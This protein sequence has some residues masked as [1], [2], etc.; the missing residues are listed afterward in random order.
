MKWVMVFMAVGVVCLAAGVS[1]EQY[2]QLRVYPESGAEWGVLR[3]L[4]LDVAASGP[5]WMEIISSPEEYAQLSAE[6]LRIEVLQEDLERFYAERLGAKAGMGGYMTLAEVNA[7]LDTLVMNFPDLVSAKVQIGTTHEGRPIWAVKI[8]DNPNVDEDEPELLFTAA[9]HAREVIT[10][11]TVFNIMEYLAGYYNYMPEVKGMVDTR[12]IWFV[13]MC[14]PDGYYYN[15]VI[16]PNGGGMWRKNR[17]PN[18]DGSYGVDLN[19]NFGYMWGYDDFGSSPS[20]D[21]MTYRGPGPFSE[22]ETQAIRDFMDSHDFRTAV[23]YHSYGNLILWPWGY[24]YLPCDHDRIFRTLGDS[25]RTYNGYFA[26]SGTALYATNGGVDDWAYATR[27]ERYCF[28][29]EIGSGSDGFWPDPS[30][31]TELVNQNFEPAL[32]LIRDVDNVLTYG[33][34]ARP[35]V[36][37]EPFVDTSSYTV[38]WQCNDT[39]NPPTQYELTELSGAFELRDEANDFDNWHNAGF[40]ISSARS[41]SEPSSFHSGIENGFSILQIA[42]PRFVEEGDTLRFRI[43]YDLYSSF[44]YAYVYASADG[45]QAVSLRGNITTTVDPYGLNDGNGITGSSGGNWVEAVFDLSPVAGRS[46]VLFLVNSPVNYNPREGIYIDDI[47]PVTGFAQAGT[48]SSGTTDTA[49]SFTSHEPGAYYYRV[50]AMDAQGEW[51]PFSDDIMTLVVDTGNICVDAD[52]DGYGDPAVV[53]NRCPDDNCP[54][55]ANADQADAD[56]DLL[57]DACDNCPTVANVDQADG[58]QD[59]IGDACDACP[60]DPDNDADGDGHCAGADNCVLVFNPTQAD[61]DMDGIG[62]ACCCA[63]RGDVNGDSKVIVSD[64]TFLVNF[65]FKSGPTAAC[66][67]EGDVNNDTKVLV[68]D[69]TYMVSYLFR[70]GPGPSGC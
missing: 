31:I 68:S 60:T 62:D 58:D 57:G 33:V 37:I 3:S 32:Y 24:D 5:G 36:T 54:S 53:Q 28:T 61:Q 44:E 50:R 11:L 51:G 67:L 22:P 45:Q 35:T 48:V 13:P 6:G 12:E 30:R 70:S 39:I 7:R 55:M 23:F 10:P 4:P 25:M 21:A 38:H 17:R 65:L 18:G 15:E 47:E 46:V 34:P 27:N 2:M 59:G 1:A 41:Y 63:L 9:I 19:R 8:S 14:N 42:Q 49:W 56:G 64:L 16:A 69:L 43:W 40:T 29:V 52:N 26:G 66:P 20:P